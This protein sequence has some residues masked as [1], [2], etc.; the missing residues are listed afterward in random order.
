[1]TPQCRATIHFLNLG[2]VQCTLR[3]GHPH[4]HAH[5]KIAVWVYEG[6]KATGV[7]SY[8]GHLEQS[9]PYGLRT[10]WPK[11]SRLLKGEYS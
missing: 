11:G 1:M 9:G 10:H 5:K 6:D 8:D 7:A 2:E 3:E 4:H